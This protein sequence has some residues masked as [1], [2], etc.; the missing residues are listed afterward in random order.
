MV[1]MINGERIARQAAIRTGCSAVIFDAQHRVLLTRRSDN[2]KWCI[3]GGGMDPGE[4]AEETC[5]REVLEETGLQVRV[6]RLVGIY[7]DPNFLIQYADGN[8][9]QVV[10]MC[11]EAEVIGGTP[12]LSDET[13]DIGYFSEQEIKALDIHPFQLQRVMDAFAFQER[14]Y[15]R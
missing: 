1:K 4:S 10:A 15:I 13:T 3:P 11:F 2:G 12:G 5:V 6:L 14:A 8:R 9:F 7:S